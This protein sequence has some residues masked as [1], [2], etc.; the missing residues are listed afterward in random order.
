MGKI[1][2]LLPNFGNMEKVNDDIATLSKSNQDLKEQVDKLSSKSERKESE[3]T[4]H[5][6]VFFSVKNEFEVFRQDVEEKLQKYEELGKDFQYF[7]DLSD[8]R[9]RELASNFE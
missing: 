7:R 4:K 6:I 1:G 8:R 9:F 5:N 3:I 2:N